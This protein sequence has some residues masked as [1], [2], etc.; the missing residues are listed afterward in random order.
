MD[1]RDEGVLLGVR[2]HGEANAIIDVLTSN[3]GR[4]AGL[5]RGGRSSEM[6]AILQPGAQL[7][8]EWGARLGDH[9]GNYKVDLIKARAADIMQDRGSLSGLN[10]ITSLLL[11][12]L[13]ERDPVPELYP[14]TIN[15][16]DALAEGR[17]HWPV[18]YAKWE[19]ELLSALGFPVDLTSCAATGQRHDLVYVSP[20]SGRAVSRSPGG[21]WADR[22]LP[23]P[24]FL[25]NRGPVSMGA[26]REAV[27][28]TGYFLENWAA[29]AFEQTGLPEA[30]ARLLRIFDTHELPDLPPPEPPGGDEGEFNRA[31]GGT[32]TELRVATRRVMF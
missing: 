29:P 27:R 12:M 19:V 30:R 13:P 16:V 22:L 20:R 7:I 14:A 8:C 3:N 18:D 21:A 23:L 15:L 9:L 4:Y 24:G 32:G 5:V 2:S 31:M 11:A 26:V 25:I 10:A 1:W 17:P 6:A 28:M